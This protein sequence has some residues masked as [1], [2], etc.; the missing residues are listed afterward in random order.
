MG[1]PLSLA[2]KGKFSVWGDAGKPDM[3]LFSA[4]GALSQ[5][6][7]CTSRKLHVIDFRARIII[8]EIGYL[9]YLSMKRLVGKRLDGKLKVGKNAKG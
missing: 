7:D 4:L 2:S 3:L 1:K 9:A 8:I 5:S 6:S